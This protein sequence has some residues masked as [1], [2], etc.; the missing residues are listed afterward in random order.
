MENIKL[1]L[2][3]NM[4]IIIYSLFALLIVTFI[5]IIKEFKKYD[6]FQEE[7]IK[8]LLEYIGNEKK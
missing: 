4:D 6:K 3:E 7:I 8:G 2:F 5:I 1:I